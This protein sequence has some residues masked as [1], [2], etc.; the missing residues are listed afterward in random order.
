[1]SVPSRDH[2][3]S[4]SD[5]DALLPVVLAELRVLARRQL[6]AERAQQTLQ[7]TDLVHE[8]YLRLAGSGDVAGRGRA[9]FFAAAARAMR[10]VLVDAARRRG[11]ARRG[12]G[13]ALVTL[14]EADASVDAYA[15][16]LLAL[17]QALAELEARDPRRARV[18]ECRF[19]AGL[20]VEETAVALGV[21]PRTVK[22]DWAFARA[23]LADRLDVGAPR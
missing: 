5:L 1:M 15:D 7:T 23:W 19:F 14:G 10:Q 22:G 11:A 3:A 17:E 18:V 6:S 20:S 9:Y 4:T 13:V 8:A 12:G 2:A 21:S 16:E